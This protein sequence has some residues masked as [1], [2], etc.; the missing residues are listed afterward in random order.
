[1]T[2]NSFQ[3]EYRFLSNFWP[4]LVTLDGL[5]YKSVEHAYMAAKTI[6]TD[7][8]LK[9]RDF[10]TPGEAK[11]FCKTIILRPDW[12]TLKYG[13]MLD[14]IEQKFSQDPLKS[15]LLNTGDVALIEGNTWNDT[16]WGVC[17]GKGQNNLGRILMIVREGLKGK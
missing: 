8:R 15:R 12:D 2:I 1:M 13:I 5:E 6:K 14:L 16:Y 10:A 7:L 3:G 4:A 17:N 9:I 11:K